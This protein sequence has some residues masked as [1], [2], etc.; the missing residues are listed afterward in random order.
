MQS[1]ESKINQVRNAQCMY[2]FSPWQNCMLLGQRQ[3]E[4]CSQGT[5][6]F[7]SLHDVCMSLCLTF[8]EYLS[9]AYY[10]PTNHA[11]T[12]QWL[13]DVLLS[14]RPARTAGP[15]KDLLLTFWSLVCYATRK[16][17]WH[18]TRGLINILLNEYKRERRGKGPVCACK[19]IRGFQPPK[20]ALPSTRNLMT[21]ERPH[22][23]CTAV[24][25]AAV[26]QSSLGPELRRIQPFVSLC[27]SHNQNE[28]RPN[29]NLPVNCMFSTSGFQK[30]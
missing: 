10:L 15:R 24:G 23:P 4:L 3:Y 29:V 9:R 30:Y 11:G 28:V 25:T 19:E 16:S 12:D 2:I 13:T 6:F 14:P 22:M 18:M 5:V 7:P 27:L 20:Q 26:M 8:K 1:W 17:A 21:S